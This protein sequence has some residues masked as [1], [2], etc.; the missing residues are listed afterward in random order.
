MPIYEY[1]CRACDEVFESD[2][3]P[4]S[5]A[6]QPGPCPHCNHDPAPEEQ[7]PQL[8]AGGFQLRGP[9]WASDGYAKKE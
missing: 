9:G 8:S 6:R 4:M 3:K 1:R 7:A 5:E 2:I